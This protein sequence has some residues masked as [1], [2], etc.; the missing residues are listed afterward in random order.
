MTRVREKDHKIDLTDFQDDF[1]K[2]SRIVCIYHQRK[3]VASARMVFCEAND[4]M[5]L[6]RYVALPKDFPRKE[7]SM[8]I[9]RLCVDPNY[10][11]S[12]LLLSLFKELT[13]IGLLSNRDYVVLT[14]PCELLSHYKKLGAKSLGM[15]FDVAKRF[16]GVILFAYKPS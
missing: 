13:Y 5:E 15:E 11:K 4:A 7:R 12:D 16:L 8:E 1:D 10:R 3:L 6:E 9:S 2:R 14:S